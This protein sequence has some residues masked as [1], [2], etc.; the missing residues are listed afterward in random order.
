VSDVS[1]AVMDG[2]DAVMLSAESA[3]GKYPVEAVNMQQRIIR[4]VDAQWV[5]RNVSDQASEVTR[6]RAIRW[7]SDSFQLTSYLCISSLFFHCVYLKSQ[8][9]G[10]RS[11][12]EAVARHSDEMGRTFT[13]TDAI[14]DAA[15]KVAKQVVVCCFYMYP[16]REGSSR[17][18]SS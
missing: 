12:R 2:A 15:R 9:E 18:R 6:Q 10:D 5:V 3:A 11:F 14:T 17:Q 16:S 4:L 1:P 13:T 7:S 8:V